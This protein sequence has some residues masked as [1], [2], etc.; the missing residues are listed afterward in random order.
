MDVKEPTSF[1][2]DL[3]FDRVVPGGL[4]VFDDYNAVAGETEAVDE[5]MVSKGLQIEKMGLNYI[6]AFVR[7]P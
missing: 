4:I 3:L 7:K 5:F 1:A 6:P 2:L